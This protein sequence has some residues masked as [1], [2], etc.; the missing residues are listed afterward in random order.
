MPR[1]NVYIDGFNLY[2][3]IKRSSYKWLDLSSLCS[4][5][6]PSSSI[7]R[8]YYFTAI[9]KALPHDPDAPV[10]QATYFRALRTLT[11]LEIRD[12]GHFVQWGKWFPKYP[13]YYDPSK[14]AGSP[15][16]SVKVLKT[17]EKG[18]DVNLA[19]FLLKDCYNNNFDEA[20]IIS[21]DSDLVTPIDIVINECGKRV[22]VINPH[23]EKYLSRDLLNVS[24]RCYR[25]INFSAYR[26]SQFPPVM[27]DSIGTFTKPAV[28]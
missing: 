10:R 19:S 23:R 4:K 2:Y 6:L 22:M 24:T 14:P 20:I 28:W 12:E 11:N 15:P 17:E 25:E 13:L 18:S 26:D 16:E 3:A 1:A 27:S 8:I 5:L 21:N 9:V 7:Q